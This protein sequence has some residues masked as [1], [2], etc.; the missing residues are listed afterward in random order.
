MINLYA[1]FC[2]DNKIP[3][4]KAK[5]TYE[6][7]TVQIRKP[8]EIDAIINNATKE[9]SPCF[10]IM[11]ETAIEP[12]ELHNIPITEIDTSKPNAVINVIGTKEHDNGTYYL[13]TGTSDM[14]REYLK[15]RKEKK[16]NHNLIQPIQ[17]DP[18]VYPFPTQN[19]LN[20]SWVRA[21]KQA[22]KKTYNPELENIEL[23]DLRNFAG[24]IHYL[25]MGRCT[26]ETK[27]FMRHKKLEQTE[28]YLK[29]IKDFSLTLNKIG[30]CVTTAEEAMELILN[31][32]K[33][34]AVFH[35][36]TPNEKH[37]LTKMTY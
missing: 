15:F 27:K 20:T 5:Y 13:S 23:K 32:F 33:E 26:L 1:V 30:K 35:Q 2:H 25:T 34:E 31:G 18:S 14:L 4:R 17:K 3:F 22:A 24:A 12:A 8:E 7:P 16:H 19:S 11:K 37:I 21:R 36:G 29:G 9:S 28:N 6:P 10:K